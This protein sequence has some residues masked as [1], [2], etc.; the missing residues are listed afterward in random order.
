MINYLQSLTA[1]GET[2]LIVK[3][4]P[5]GAWVPA[6]PDKWK[7][8]QSWYGNTGS[9][10]LDRMKDGLSASKA[11]CTH[12]IAA[13]LDD[14]G[15]KSKAPTL[16][17][18]WI[19]ET[20]A[21][22]YQWGYAFSDQPTTG[23][24]SAFIT[25][26]ADAGYTDPGATNA[27]RN[28]RLPGS[29]NLKPGKQNFE[30]RLVEFH[31]ERQYTLQ[32]LIDALGVVPKEASTSTIQVTLADDG[33]DDVLAWLSEVG[34]VTEKGNSSGWWGVVCPNAE[35]HTDGESSGRYFPAT[36][37]YSCLHAH[38]MELTSEVFLKWVADAGGPDREHGLRSELLV[39]TMGKVLSVIKPTAAF[40]NVAAARI[41]E[42]RRK[43]LGRVEK[44]DWYARFGYVAPDDTYFDLQDRTEITRKAFNA[45][46]RHIGNV[47]RH[48]TARIEASV[49][50]D[51]WRQDMGA[52]ALS[53][54]TYAAG[55]TE[56]V[57]RDGDVYGNRWRNARPLGAA[58]DITPWLEHCARLVPD[59][60]EREHTFDIMACKV[61]R[62]DIKI[63]HA[64]LHAGREGCGKDSY[65]A[66]MIWAVCGP[67]QRNYGLLDMDTLT[68]Q[69]HYALESEIVVFNELKEPDAKER[70]SLAN[71]LKP[72]IAAPP[73]FLAINR[74]GLS[75]YMMVNRVLVLAFSNEQVPISLP[76]QDRRWFCL[77]SSSPRMS[78]EEGSRLWKWYKS[79]GFKS[80]AAWLAARDVSAFNPAAAPMVTDY[81]LNLLESGM[82]QAESY[83]V[84]AIRG[85][86][87]EFAAGVIGSPFHALC[88]RLM[89]AAP[90]GARIPQ[91]ALLHALD[92]AG[93]V[94]M[95]RIKSREHGTRKHVYCAPEMAGHTLSDLRAIVEDEKKP[96]MVPGLRAV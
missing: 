61:Q 16:P 68:S 33:T 43:E 90:Q 91:A 82:S 2:L 78:G 21:G 12:V 51:Q 46:Y 4:K 74:K 40:P 72:I 24:Y 93:W 87:G 15:T 13:L 23:E 20:S 42:V 22:N 57:T 50:F 80:V 96:G 92:E 45:L 8:G 83:L 59:A 28:F 67:D 5:S 38:C 88:D 18:T 27:V 48:S 11:N 31:P 56:L 70:R 64:V 35:E 7:A 66:P 14:I 41:E 32:E 81:K 94:D 19:M 3:Q 30:A 75:P 79:S 1:E 10:I 49:C 71:K 26:A 65:W 36:R 86:V 84:A 85:R 52:P 89:G 63:N 73:E 25:A 39:K 95:G 60:A 34:L 44:A 54:I 77:W 69:F 76:S 37:S 17:P 47:S 29:I 9:F 6:L 55:G 62:P 58:G 53:G